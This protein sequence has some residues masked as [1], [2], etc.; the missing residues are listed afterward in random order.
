[1]KDFADRG[2]ELPM[3]LDDVVVNFDQL[4]T[5]AAVRALLEFAEQGQQIMMFTCHLHL[6][7]LFENQGVEPIWLPA[8]AGAG[9]VA[10]AREG[11]RA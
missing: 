5:E 1:M 6:A 10:G 8:R 7:H 9:T 11:Q 4:R 2:V 3:V